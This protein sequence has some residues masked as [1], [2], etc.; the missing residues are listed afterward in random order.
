MWHGNLDAIVASHQD[1]ILGSTQMGDTHCQP[2]ADRQQSHREGKSSDVGQHPLP[3]IIGF[4]PNAL[5]TRQIAGDFE[6]TNKRRLISALG[7]GGPRARPE[8]EHAV[9]VFRGGRCNGSL[10]SHR[11]QLR[12]G[13]VSFSMGALLPEVKIKIAGRYRGSPVCIAAKLI[14]APCRGTC[15]S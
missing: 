8:L 1:T 11:C 3:V 6:P 12:D 14:R 2:Y 7:E 13:F 9:L 10:G 15:C 5:V 4:F